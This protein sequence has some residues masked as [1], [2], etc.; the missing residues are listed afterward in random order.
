VTGP[1][2]RGFEGPATPYSAGHRG[3]DIA[4][5]V[6]TGIRAPETGIVTFAGKVAGSLFLTIDHGAGI[7]SSFSW[8][9]QLAVARG[10]LVK[11]GQIVAFTGHGHPDLEPTHLHFGI[12]LN[13]TY[14]DPLD[15]L[16]PASVVDLIRLAPL[17][18]PEPQPATGSFA[19]RSEVVASGWIR[20]L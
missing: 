9:S 7:R 11:R 17:G 19:L 10:T 20:P 4:A 3:I 13:G 2:I 16:E 15:Y 8:L 1:V 18:E 6:G 12:R 14:V 5:P